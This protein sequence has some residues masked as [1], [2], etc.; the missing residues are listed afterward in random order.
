MFAA[1]IA[2]LLATVVTVLAVS[3]D[4]ASDE[5]LARWERSNRLAITLVA[6][7]AHVSAESVSCGQYGGYVREH[8][9]CDLVPLTGQCERWR[10]DPR[11]AKRVARRIDRSSVPDEPPDPD[12]VVFCVYIGTVDDGA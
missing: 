8:G 6:R 3:P 1:V 12:G 11:G 5:T 10:F 2:A 9:T 7:R 4:G